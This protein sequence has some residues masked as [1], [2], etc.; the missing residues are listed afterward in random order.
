METVEN[1]LRAV[2]FHVEMVHINR[3]LYVILSNRSSKSRDQ[4]LWQF[5][6][7]A[8]MCLLPIDVDKCQ[9]G[10]ITYYCMDDSTFRHQKLLVPKDH[11]LLFAGW[12]I[13]V[14]QFLARFFGRIN[15]GTKS[16]TNSTEKKS[17]Q[18]SMTK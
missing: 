17:I 5:V 6:A 14:V 10:K 18:I 12:Y 15:I 16:M 7:I 2:L 4:T 11:F 13:I 9:V 3:D 8:Q 1:S